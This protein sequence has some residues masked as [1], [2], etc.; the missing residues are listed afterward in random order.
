[1]MYII[2]LIMG[3][4]SYVAIHLSFDVVV[5]LPF[6]VSTPTS[7]STV[8]RRVYRGCVVSICG[9]DMLVDLVELDML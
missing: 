9:R 4:I 7:D 5:F 1:M 2:Y 3:L 8:V 6:F